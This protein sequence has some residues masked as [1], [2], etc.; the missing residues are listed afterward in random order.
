MS[1]MSASV[2]RAAELAESL[3]E[4]RS[5]VQKAASG[6]F[7]PTLVAVSKFKPAS[8]IAVCYEH[9][10]L[11]FGENYVQELIEKAEALPKDIRWHFIGTLQSNKAKSLA[12]I[13]NLHTIQTLSSIKTAKALNKALPSD[14]A[15]PLN[16]LIQINTSGE[17]A[18]SGL[19]PLASSTDVAA[20][21]LFQLAKIMITECP[22]LRL[23]GL[24]T[25]GSLEQSL[26]ASETDQNADFDRLKETRDV[27]QN[28]L[29]AELGDSDQMK[30]GQDGILVL[31]MGMSSD[32]EAA[33]KAGSD[34]VRVG[35]G[36]FG[37]RLKK[38]AA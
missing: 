14:R 4:I 31:S 3:S 5:R 24:M 11:D 15:A 1:T 16:I 19:P 13:P 18:K 33:L 27:L 12:S 25:I 28:A 21:E 10:Q 7:P 9:G 6:S 23:Q 36:I 22:K 17:E 8:D 34:I 29:R 20:S 37:E 26:T 32:F 30:W 2:E 35:T 38:M